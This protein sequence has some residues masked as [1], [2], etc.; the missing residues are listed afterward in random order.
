MASG[1]ETPQE[2]RYLTERASLELIQFGI[3]T[4]TH[5]EAHTVQ[6]VHST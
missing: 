1:R 6:W 4:G 2:K 5:I 3:L